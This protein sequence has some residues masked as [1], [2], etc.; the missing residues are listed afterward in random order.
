MALIPN[1]YAV[2]IG[3]YFSPATNFTSLSS[4]VNVILPTVFLIAGVVF[5]VM[6]VYAGIQII[7]AGSNDPE[8]MKKLRATMTSAIA[9]LIIIVAAYW[10]VRII[11]MVTGVN[12]T[13]SSL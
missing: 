12:T 9:G 3:D 2:K 4:L 10:I 1:A 11:S 6:I 5:F 7:A 13:G 8:K